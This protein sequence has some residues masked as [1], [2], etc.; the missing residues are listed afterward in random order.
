MPKFSAGDRIVLA[1][2]NAGKL[3]EFRELL[4]P[5]QIEVVA[6]HTL[7][8]PEP[9][10]TGTTF[11]ENAILKAR[12]AAD[13]A[14]LPALADDSGLEIA[15]LD[16]APGIYS[17]RWAGPSK[18]FH[19]A[20]QR[21][22]DEVV[23]SA[24]GW[25]ALTDC[26][27]QGPIANFNATL[28]IAWPSGS[29][30]FASAVKPGPPDTSAML[31]AQIGVF[32]GKVFGHLVWPPRGEN[33]FGYDAIF[34]P[35]GHDKTFAEMTSVEKHGDAQAEDGELSH[36]ARAMKQFALACLDKTQLDARRPDLERSGHRRP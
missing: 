12:A 15:A 18:D 19:V 21:V 33:G 7:G 13:A 36:R 11:A 17:A 31:N 4:E 25:P 35:C 32:E 23:A 10:E 29:G 14:N 34:C 2:H 26:T 16:G 28:A 27:A 9:E 5:F 1:S 30:A 22:H 3:K 24:T 6:A 20:M 8:L